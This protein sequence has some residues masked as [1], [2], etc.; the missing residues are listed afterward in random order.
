MHLRTLLGGLVC[1]SHSLIHSSPFVS[2]SSFV[3]VAPSFGSLRFQQIVLLRSPPIS[4]LFM[5]LR[6]LLLLICFP[7]IT[8]LAL[9]PYGQQGVRVS[10][11][12]EYG[13]YPLSIA[14]P[15]RNHYYLFRTKW[16]K[17]GVCTDRHTT[18][19]EC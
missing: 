15:P 11:P 13:A 9:V 7:L 16:S 17:Q 6:S 4:L 1:S 5:A 12:L 10:I 8:F 14:M 19:R 18:V 3:S 2:F